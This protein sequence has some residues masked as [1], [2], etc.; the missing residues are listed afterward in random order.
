MLADARISEK[1]PLSSVQR[2]TGVQPPARSRVEELRKFYEEAL[3]L[4]VTL[5]SNKLTVEAG[6]TRLIF[7]ATDSP[8]DKEPFYHYAFNIPVSNFMN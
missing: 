2:W 1:R 3:D 8:A 7:S 6:T 4:P 5:D